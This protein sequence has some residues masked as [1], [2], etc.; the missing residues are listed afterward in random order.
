MAKQTL[1]VTPE[2]A[3]R[4]LGLLDMFGTPEHAA[5]QINIQLAAIRPYGDRAS[6]RVLMVLNKLA[7]RTDI[8]RHINAL[9]AI[10]AQAG[11][12][13]DTSSERVA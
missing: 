12:A 9:K 10:A 1:T 7:G 13:S 3:Q 11:H 5:H 6:E 2:T 4:T 8:D